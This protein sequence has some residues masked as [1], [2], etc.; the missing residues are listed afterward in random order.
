VVDQLTTDESDSLRLLFDQTVEHALMLLDV[1]GRITAWFAGAEQTFG[2]R[3]DEVLGQSFSMLFSPE[4]RAAGMDRYELAVAESGVEAEDDRWMMRKNGTRFWAGGVVT[5]IRDSSGK[6]LAFGKLLR[7]RT[8]TREQL[9]ALAN[10]NRSLQEADQRKNQFI[11]TLAHELRNPLGSVIMAI[12]VLKRTG[13]TATDMT[14]IVPILEREAGLMRRLVDDLND[15]TRAESGKVRLDKERQDLRSIIESAVES[16]RGSVQSQ[17]TIHTI[18]SDVPICVDVDA[19]RIRQVFVNLVQNAATA[20]RNGGTI[21]IKVAL[22]G[23][24]AVVKVEDTGVGI[25]PEVIPRIFDLFT[26]AEFAP[27]SA[28]AGLGIGLSVVKNLTMLHGGSVQV[29]SDGLGKGSEF[30]VRL[31]LTE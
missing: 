13:G 19:E 26:Q 10:Q 31:P 22:E 21:W 24:Q 20:T 11:S 8:D 23:D 6:L 28:G 18:M 4:G 7:D 30:T 25:S 15:A 2:Y 17:Q 3:A 12:E 27:D 29:R 16:C 1:E 5:P 14:Q 9:D